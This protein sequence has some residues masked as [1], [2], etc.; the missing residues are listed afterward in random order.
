[1]NVSGSY[2]GG[3]TKS[4]ASTLME[5]KEKLKQMRDEDERE[6]TIERERRERIERQSLTIESCY[7][8]QIPKDTG[9]LLSIDA[10]A[11]KC[12]VLE[13]KND[14]DETNLKSPQSSPR[15][16]EKRD[17]Q[18]TRLTAHFNTTDNRDDKS[19]ERGRSNE[20]G[21]NSGHELNINTTL[22][23]HRP[24]NHRPPLSVKKDHMQHG[25]TMTN[26]QLRGRRPLQNPGVAT[27]F[28]EPTQRSK[29]KEEDI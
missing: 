9:T 15:P 13:E 29:D 24:F 27:E 7:E 4:L 19:K 22:A 23:N 6:R 5:N 3:L 16:R 14:G 12:K 25:L 21:N 8:S 18:G 11:E 17:D 1:M 20:N 10:T 2:A 28:T 26:K